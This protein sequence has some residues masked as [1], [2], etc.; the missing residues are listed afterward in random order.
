M[1]Y[2]GI[3]KKYD[4]IP[5]HNV[6]FAAD[7]RKNVEEIAAKKLLSDDPSVY[8]QNAS[9]TDPTLAGEGKSTLYL[10]VPVPN[11]RSKINWDEI[12]DTFTEK[13]LDLVIKR[14][15]FDGLREHIEVKKVITPKDWEEKHN[16]HA[17]ATFNLAHNF[18]QLLYF[19][20]RNKF[21]ELEHCYLV[22]GGTH[23]GS[24]LPTIYESGRIS[25]NL[26]CKTYGVKFKPPT[27]LKAK[28]GNI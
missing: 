12:K 10:L 18:T 28:D 21:E 7:Y 6:L 25:S 9:V 14:G 17:G 23:P 2:L 20:P 22:G 1:V 4:S 3:N 16:I 5:H 24:G 27:S 19:R 15:G 11:N 26:L 8:V 13:V